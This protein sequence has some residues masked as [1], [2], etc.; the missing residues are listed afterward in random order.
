M[1]APGADISQHSPL[2]THIE[3][4][5]LFIVLLLGNKSTMRTHTLQT[6]IFQRLHRVRI[7]KPSAPYP[8]L[9]AP[10]HLLGLISFSCFNASLNAMPTYI[11]FPC[12]FLKRSINFSLNCLKNSVSEYRVPLAICH[13][14][15]T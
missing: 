6:L 4:L 1:G 9:S 8:L 2:H 11:R 13:S 5:S 7:A 10:Y 14:L 12:E 15:K 3:L